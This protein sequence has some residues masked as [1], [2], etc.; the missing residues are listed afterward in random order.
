MKPSLPF[1]GIACCIP[2]TTSFHSTMYFWIFQVT[3]PCSLFFQ[4]YS[5]QYRTSLYLAASASA[6]FFADIALCPLESVK[7]RVQTSHG[8]GTT[9]RE[10]APILWRE[11]KLAG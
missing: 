2:L 1:V 10:C 9:L 3:L 11:E 4:E 5:Y 6:E 8:Y 7:V